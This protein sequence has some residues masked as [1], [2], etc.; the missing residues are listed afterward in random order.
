MFGKD[1]AE[2]GRKEQPGGSSGLV[3]QISRSP[4]R[5]LS[6]GECLR[7]AEFAVDVEEPVEVLLSSESFF[8]E[9]TPGAT[10]IAEL[11]VRHG[12]HC[13]ELFGERSSVARGCE[14]AGFAG[15]DEFG[16][17]AEV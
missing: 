13:R 4:A 3:F 16:D 12:L 2:L 5:H 10:H 17:A 14:Q 7:C 9:G 6:K 15:H 1:F 11:I 8:D